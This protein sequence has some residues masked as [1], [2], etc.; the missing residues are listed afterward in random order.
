MSIACPM[1][2]DAHVSTLDRVRAERAAAAKVKR[3]VSVK[4]VEANRRN[5]RRST[6]PR[7]AP[8]KARASRN[9]LKH[10][11]C[12]TFARLPGEEEAAFDTFVAELEAEMRPR[13]TLQRNL[14]P[15]IANLLWRVRRLPEAE[16][17][18]FVR[19]SAKAADDDVE[20][21]SS[22]EVL[23]RRFSD[24]PKNGFLLMGRYER[25]M[26]N[27]LLRMI[28]QFHALQKTHPTT[29]YAD[30]DGYCPREGSEPATARLERYRKEQ[31]ERAEIAEAVSRAFDARE[32]H[33]AE[34]AAAF[35]K[36][37]GVPLNDDE[38]RA[39]APLDCHAP[40]PQSSPGGRGD[41]EE[42]G[43]RTQ[44]KPPENRDGGRETRKCSTSSHAPVT[45]RTHC[46]EGR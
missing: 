30:G 46:E 17:A 41:E 43:K 15:Q 13:T 10:G 23:A 39:S 1:F 9:A 14:F 8:G 42:E 32:R 19:E 40:S 3:P 4:R 24:D 5:A 7:T 36:E 33:V 28:R 45:K 26:Q 38:Q 22:A 21:L 12:G 44:T 2:D 31:R 11:L 6:G 18:L 20:M 27:A 35:E 25:G 34:D 37:Y 29:P 16:T